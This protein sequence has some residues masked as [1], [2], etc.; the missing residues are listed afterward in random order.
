MC[1]LYS[2]WVFPCKGRNPC[3]GCVHLMLVIEDGLDHEC[4]FDEVHPVVTSSRPV[5]VGGLLV[6]N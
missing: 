4:G 5:L 2:E 1:L 6:Y 3:N